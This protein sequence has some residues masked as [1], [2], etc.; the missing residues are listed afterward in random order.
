MLYN[1]VPSMT[2][3]IYYVIDCKY[4]IPLEED[5]FIWQSE[6]YFIGSTDFCNQRKWNTIPNLSRVTLLLP[7]RNDRSG[8]V[9]VVFSEATN[10]GR[11]FFLVTLFNVRKVVQTVDKNCEAYLGKKNMLLQLRIH[12]LRNIF[13][14]QTLIITYYMISVPLLLN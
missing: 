8:F 1:T 11:K 6:E 14:F 7:W 12:E 10:F 5:M 4:V 2:P 3:H 13:Q 9:P